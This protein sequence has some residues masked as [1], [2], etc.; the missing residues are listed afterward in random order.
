[1][2]CFH[3]IYYKLFLS[4]DVGDCEYTFVTHGVGEM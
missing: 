4:V 3:E 2:K 1:M